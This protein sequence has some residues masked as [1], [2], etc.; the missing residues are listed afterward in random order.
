MTSGLDKCIAVALVAL[1]GLFI[2]RT[3]HPSTQ[4]VADGMD[5]D[6]DQAARASQDSG[7]PTVV[8]F[9]A[10][11]CPA[12]QSLHNSV[13]SRDDVRHEL[14]GHYSLYTV[15][16]THPSPKVQ[17]HARNLHVSYIP[18]LIRYDKN[19]NETARTNYLG[20]EQMIAW[21]KAGE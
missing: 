8:L 18:L 12:C 6:W 15:D 9:T 4:F 16:L 1:V 10:G 19:G 17:A 11:W 7:Q 5:T 21:L 2:Y 14:F 13:L 20:P 3:I